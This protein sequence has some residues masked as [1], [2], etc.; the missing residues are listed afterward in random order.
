MNDFHIIVLGCMGGPYEDNM[1]G[2][3]LSADGATN[4]IAL[5]GGSL[6]AGIAKALQA[7]NLTAL[8][9]KQ[10]LIEHVKAYLISHAHL[11]HIAGL[12]INSQIDKKKDIY[13][14][15][16]TIDHISAHIFNGKIWPNYGSEGEGALHKY[17]YHRVLPEKAFAIKESPFSATPFILDHPEPH[18]STAFL[19]EAFGKYLLYFGD[20]ASDRKCKNKKL[21][22]IWQKIAPLINQG[23]LKG[24]LLECSYAHANSAEIIFGHLDTHTMIEELRELGK[25][26]KSLVGLKVVVTHRKQLSVASEK[27]PHVIEKELNH[28]ND[29]GLTFIFPK[30][31]DK[32][33]F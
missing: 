1:S 26:C 23:L 15:D 12:V 31:G 9:A 14:L 33:T 28:L 16:E 24:I 27:A 5:D 17:T 20:T 22:P 11:D 7:G 29:L 18:Q 32:I 3:L 30:Q 6:L 25:L 2:Y 4:F 21:A 8:S 19:I 10:L 13:A